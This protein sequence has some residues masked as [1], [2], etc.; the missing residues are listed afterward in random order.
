MMT[1][2]LRN[3]WKTNGVQVIPGDSLDVTTTQTAG[4]ERAAAINLAQVGA[5]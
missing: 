3:T 4:M 5:Q 1:D 2:S